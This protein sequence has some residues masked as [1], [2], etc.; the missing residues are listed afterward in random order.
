MAALMAALV[1][2]MLAQASDRTPWAAAILAGRFRRPAALLV[3]AAL[4]FAVVNAI[5]AVAG[6]MIAPRITPEARTLFLALALANAGV[7]ALLPLKRPAPN[8]DG[9][10]AFLVSLFA[11]LAM[12]LGDRTQFLTAAIAARSTTP[13]FAAAG[14]TLGSLAVVVPATLAGEGAYL[15]LPRLP[16]RIAIGLLFALDALWTALGALRLI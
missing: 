11:L 13:L 5:G 10:G 3:A 4:A 14:A 15:R 1:A 12:G 9:S 6:Q 8:G 7:M 16:I 2:A